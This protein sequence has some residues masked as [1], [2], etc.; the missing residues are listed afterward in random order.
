MALDLSFFKVFID[1][2]PHLA[3]LQC[4][5]RSNRKSL[6]KHLVGCEK[7][8]IRALQLQVINKQP[9][10]I[11]Y[12][13]MSITDTFMHVCSRRRMCEPDAEKSQFKDDDE[14][15]SWR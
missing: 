2:G 5:H 1:K 11:A 15:K 13:F 12:A 4:R 7:A 6:E 9:I 10:F 14:M 3:G 8:S